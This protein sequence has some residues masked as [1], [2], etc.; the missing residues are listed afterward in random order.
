MKRILDEAGHEGAPLLRLGMALDFMRLL[1]AVDHK[2][3]SLSKR[4]TRALGVT[5]PQRLAIRVVGL[6]P[7][8]SAGDL[9]HILCV[10]PSTLTGILQRLLA[11][12]LLKIR[13][14]P[15]DRR[16]MRLILTPRGEKLCGQGIGGTIESAVRRA[17]KR[18]DR[19]QLDA[20]RE[21]LRLLERELNS[22]I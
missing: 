3:Q 14:D 19:D 5:G 9:S 10:H 22:L 1:W 2:L 21:V 4:M 18:I 15:G 7:N 8:I 13:R 16:R 12:K 17:L 6:L 20:A 11:A